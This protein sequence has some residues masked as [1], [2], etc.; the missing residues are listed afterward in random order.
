MGKGGP[1]RQKSKTLYFFPPRQLLH[2]RHQGSIIR[3]HLPRGNDPELAREGLRVSTDRKQRQ[4]LTP[5]ATWSPARAQGKQHTPENRPRGKVSTSAAG[6][7]Q[8]CS[9]SG[10]RIRGHA[11][12]PR[13]GLPALRLFQ[14][15]PLASNPGLSLPR[16]ALAVPPAKWK[17]R[18]EAPLPPGGLCALPGGERGA[19]R[20]A[21]FVDPERLLGRGNGPCGRGVQRLNFRARAPELPT[22][23]QA[24]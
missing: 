18:H 1:S 15:R 14:P 17:R 5:G 21:P 19:R 11:R 24:L 4:R 16:P 3:L 7:D 22:S 10:R 20:R 13:P 12:P 2:S 6:A 9:C 23:P 8:Q